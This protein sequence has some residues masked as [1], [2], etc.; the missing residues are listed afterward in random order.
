MQGRV[1]FAE[2][3]LKS[4]IP[5]LPYRALFLRTYQSWE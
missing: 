1:K 2:G 4:V 5:R 3:E